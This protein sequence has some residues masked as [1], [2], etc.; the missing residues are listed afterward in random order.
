MTNLRYIVVNTSI[1]DVHWAFEEEL[2]ELV[3]KVH[4]VRSHANGLARYIFLQMLDNSDQEFD[5]ER[6]INRKTL[7]REQMSNRSVGATTEAYLTEIEQ[8]RRA[9]LR[10]TE[11]TPTNIG[12][13]KQIADYECAR[14]EASY[15]NS[16]ANNFGKALRGVLNQLMN[17]KH[18]KQQFEENLANTNLNELDKKGLINQHIFLPARNFKEAVGLGKRQRPPNSNFGIFNR[19]W[20]R[21]AF[22][23]DAYEENQVFE[24]PEDRQIQETQDRLSSLNKKATTVYEFETYLTFLQDQNFGLLKNYHTDTVTL[25]GEFPLFRYL[26]L[27]SKLKALKVYQTLGNMLKDFS[28]HENGIPTLII[29][30]WSSG[31]FRYHEPTPGINLK[32]RLVRQGFRIFLI[33]EFLSS[34]TCPSYGHFPVRTFKLVENPRLYRRS[35]QPVVLRHGLLR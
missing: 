34:S 1:E 24:R 29:G 15:L 22:F 16:V 14:M 19:L 18:L 17:L 10:F 32:H 2:L 9:S 35:T 7:S 8:H 6:Y 33:N 12:D 11:F 21:M 26:K 25:N 3:K 28:I 23:F 30:D 4:D 20:E 27:K 5:S 13:F 31:N